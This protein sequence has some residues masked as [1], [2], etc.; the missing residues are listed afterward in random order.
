MAVWLTSDLHFMHE[1]V[2][3]L[4]G[5]P[6][7]GSHDADV[8]RTWKLRVRDGD[9]VWLL[10]DI[11]S[12]GAASQEYALSALASLPG[13]KMLV[14]GNHD[15]PHPRHGSRSLTWFKKYMSS[16]A[17]EWVGTS[18]RLRHDGL[19]FMLSHYPFDAD[20]VEESRDLEWR[21]PRVAATDHYLLHGHTHSTEP[22]TSEREVCVGLDAWGMA[23]APL[24]E[25][26]NLVRQCDQVTQQIV[27]TSC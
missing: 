22:R 18:A 8:M 9:T 19:K 12:G 7:T 15:A 16:G 26:T 5:Y 3:L 24:G 6:S 27:E 25:I 20:H 11:S 21:L 10:G 23:P 4:R 14:L 13:E 1:K 2:A 17:F